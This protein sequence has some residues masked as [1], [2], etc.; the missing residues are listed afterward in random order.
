M[1]KLIMIGLLSL[2]LFGANIDSFAKKMGF[3]RDYNSALLKAK[4]KAQTFD[5][6]FR[7]RLL[8]LVP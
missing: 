8:P 2:T 5:D 1:K 4:K 3:E 6:G 7:G